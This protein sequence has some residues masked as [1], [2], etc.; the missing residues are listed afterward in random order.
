MPDDEK[1][2]Q[3]ERRFQTW[4]ELPGGGRPYSYSLRG[5]L[6]WSARYVKEV[7][8]DERTVRFHQKILNPG[9]RLVEIHEKFPVDRG[10]RPVGGEN[11]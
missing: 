3:N 1:R 10:H 7:D 2:R 8:R 11:P 5:T 4:E 9:G 6:G